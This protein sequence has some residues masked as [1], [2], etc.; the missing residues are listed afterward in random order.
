[1]A[2]YGYMHMHS[3]RMKYSL[4]LSLIRGTAWQ[5]CVYWKLAENKGKVH[6]S[7]SWIRLKSGITF[8]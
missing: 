1:M 3:I 4:R 5:D 2:C 7:K 8:S 6:I